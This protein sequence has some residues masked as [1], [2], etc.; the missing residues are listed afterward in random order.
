MLASTWPCVFRSRWCKLRGW[1]E[2]ARTAVAWFDWAMEPERCKLDSFATSTMIPAG[3]ELTQT[4]TNFLRFTAYL[5]VNRSLS[6]PVSETSTDDFVINSISSRTPAAT[7]LRC[8]SSSCWISNSLNFNCFSISRRYLAMR[9]SSS[10]CFSS[11]LLSLDNSNSSW[12]WLE[13]F[14]EVIYDPDF[15]WWDV[16]C[17]VVFV[18][19]W[20]NVPFGLNQW[21]ESIK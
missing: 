10:Y 20:I 9:S 6:L 2:E 12:R 16:Y 19:D 15:E 7:C 13:L 21:T 8:C 3:D 5:S 1:A 14:E 4:W 17:S 11:F 18:L